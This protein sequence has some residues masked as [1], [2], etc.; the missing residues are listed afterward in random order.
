[1][2]EWK[3]HTCAADL[4]AIYAWYKSDSSR[5]SI[6]LS[7]DWEPAIRRWTWSAAVGRCK[8]GSIPAVYISCCVFIQFWPY[9][10]NVAA[11]KKNHQLRQEFFNI[12]FSYFPKHM[13]TVASV[14]CFWLTRWAASVVF[15]CSWSPY[16][17][18]L[19]ALI[20]TNGYLLLLTY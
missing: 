3:H 14:S 20:V 6:G 7:S 10:L 8:A 1:M 17:T 2:L 15:C 11:G 5:W 13:L 9:H 4:L 18:I 12:L 19:H 16:G